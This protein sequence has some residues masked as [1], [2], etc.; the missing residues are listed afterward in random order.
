MSMKS[1]KIHNL[2]PLKVALPALIVILAAVGAYAMIATAP[3]PVK[4]PPVD[5]APTVSTG[6][7]TTGSQPVTLSV[8]GTVIAACEINLECL[9]SGE[10]VSVSDT[11]VPGGM[12]AK[13]QKILQIN[14]QDYKLALDEVKADVTTA[15]YDL[16]VELGYQNVAGREWTLL[17]KSSKGTEQEADL[18]LRKPH[19][20]KA[21]ADLEA[22]KAK[23]EQAKLDL[24]RTTITAPFAAVVQ[25]KSVDIGA[26]V[27]AQETL[28]SLVGTDE[29][30]VEASVPVDRLNWIT[31]P[32]ADTPGATAIVVSGSAGNTSRRQ[33]R[34]VRLLP[35]LEDEGRMAR[36]LVSVKDPLNLAREPGVKPL[37]LGSYVTV[38]VDGGHLDNA[39]SIP[40]SAFRDNSRIWV[41]QPDGTLD[42]RA[43]TP[44]WRD[45]NSVILTDGLTAGERVVLSTLSTPV[46]GMRLNDIEEVKSAT[47]QAVEAGDAAPDMAPMGGSNG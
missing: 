33:G 29:F 42:I 43:V 46:Q 36:V 20:E 24:K 25:S 6:T 32:T 7:F 17:K 14:P 30:W 23:L 44:A 38:L 8:M 37:L 4:R 3:H 34:I 13:G 21:K 5:V 35:S 11:F 19:L 26:T 40:R 10:V 12:F 16:K 28:A 9:V 47:R 15:E 39:I 2:V 18:A 31:L 45:S 27:S 41:L 22:A 1:T